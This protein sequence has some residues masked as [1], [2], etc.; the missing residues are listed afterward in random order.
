MYTEKSQ[1]RSGANLTSEKTEKNLYNPVSNPVRVS[2]WC[3]ITKKQVWV[4]GRI[5]GKRQADLL[6]V[7]ECE[8]NNCPER[9]STYCLIGKLKEGVWLN[10]K[11]P[12]R[13]K[14]EKKPKKSPKNIKRYL[15]KWR[16]P[17]EVINY[18]GTQTLLAK[19]EKSKRSILHRNRVQESKKIAPKRTWFSAD[20]RRIFSSEDL[21][22]EGYCE[23][24]FNYGILYYCNGLY[25]C[26]T[27][28]DLKGC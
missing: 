9:H 21:I 6:R 28:R 8:E 11:S 15:R 4:K 12:K 19:L 1:K 2:C 24:C 23:E 5:V 18:K 26:S 13:I 16:L 20:D 22:I 17:G 25:L 10:Q 7:V 14:I 3:Y 27:C